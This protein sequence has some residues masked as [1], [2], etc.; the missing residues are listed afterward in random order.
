[1][2]FDGVDEMG[3]DDVA[4]VRCPW[5]FE[6]IELYVDPGERGVFTE[7]CEVCCR[8]WRVSVTRDAGQ[9]YV[10]VERS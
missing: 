9:L 7:D 1:M 4:Q 8:P 6:A 2:T 10:S 5:C 3:S